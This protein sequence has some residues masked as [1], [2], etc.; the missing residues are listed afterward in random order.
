MDILIL[1][2]LSDSGKAINLY[3]FYTLNPRSRNL[4]TDFTLGN[5][6]IGSIKLTKNVEPDKYA[7]SGYGI[8]FDLRSRL[9]LPDGSFGKNVI[10]FGVD[11]ITSVRIDNKKK[12]ENIL[13]LFKGP[14]QNLYNTTITAEDKYSINFTGSG[15]RFVLA[16]HYNGSNTFLFVNTTKIYQ[17]KAKDSEIKPYPLCL[18]NISKDFKIDNM[19]NA[20]LNRNLKVF[21]VD[22][23]AINTNDILHI[24]RYLMRET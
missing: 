15:K 5:C 7:Y 3:S 12:V 13:V 18:G 21:S 10:I 9:S 14:T 2:Q 4:N 17:F 23:N 8:G 6:L 1:I 20:G 16:L 19:K 11:N 24:H 22:Y